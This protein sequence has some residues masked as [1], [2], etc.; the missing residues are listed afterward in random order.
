MSTTDWGLDIPSGRRLEEERMSIRGLP[1][2]TAKALE[3][4]RR[5]W[6]EAKADDF[7]REGKAWVDQATGI[8]YRRAA[9]DPGLGGASKESV[10]VWFISADKTGDGIVYLR[11]EDNPGAVLS[12][13]QGEF[14]GW[15]K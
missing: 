10:D 12:T 5:T 14:G 11:R 8:R 9:G 6:P 15:R 13:A 2:A 3:N 1:R 4:A 7:E